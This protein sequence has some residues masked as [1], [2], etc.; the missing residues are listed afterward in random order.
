MKEDE[1][2]GIG[3]FKENV[4]LRMSFDQTQKDFYYQTQRTFCGMAWFYRDKEDGL[5]KHF[6][7]D[8]IS[9]CLN[10]VCQFIIEVKYNTYI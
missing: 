5:V 9:E 7:V 4:K 6:Y 2:L 8:A 3:D 1:A 10:H